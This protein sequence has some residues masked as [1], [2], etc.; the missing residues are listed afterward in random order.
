M[1]GSFFSFSGALEGSVVH[2]Q[3]L[4]PG[5]CQ[6]SVMV[7]G[8]PWFYITQEL[9]DTILINLWPAHYRNGPQAS[10]NPCT[11]ASPPSMLKLDR[12]LM[13]PQYLRD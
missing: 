6:Q 13:S 3:G 1:F 8:H 9:Q 5:D 10:C 12:Q 4:L 11:M 7:T 2:R